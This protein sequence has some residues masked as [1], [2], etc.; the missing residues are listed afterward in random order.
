MC[1]LGDM[2]GVLHDL[3]GK[4]PQGVEDVVQWEVLD[5]HPNPLKEQAVG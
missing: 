5:C 4:V 1:G 3:G 2:V